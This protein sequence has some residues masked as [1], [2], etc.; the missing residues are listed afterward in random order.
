MAEKNENNNSPG[1]LSG[2]NSSKKISLLRAIILGLL[3]YLICGFIFWV[4]AGVL[5]IAESPQSLDV[6]IFVLYS[7]LVGLVIGCTITYGL[8][9]NKY[10]NKKLLFIF[11]LLSSFFAYLKY[12]PSFSEARWILFF[13]RF[14]VSTL[15]DN[16][17]YFLCFCLVFSGIIEFISYEKTRYSNRFF[18]LLLSCSFFAY[19]ASNIYGKLNYY[20]CN[21]RPLY[22]NEIWGWEVIGSN[23]LHLHLLYAFCL[24]LIIREFVLYKAKQKKCTNKKTIFIWILLCSF[25]IYS[26]FLVITY[27]IAPIE[28]VLSGFW[29]FLLHNNLEVSPVSRL[30]GTNFYHTGRILDGT[31]SHGGV[32]I[33]ILAIPL[34]FTIWFFKLILHGNI[35]INNETI[36]T[37]I[38]IY[39]CIVQYLI[40]VFCAWSYIIYTCPSLSPGS[41]KTLSQKIKEF[42]TS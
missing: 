25:L 23:L 20:Y 41:Y 8:Q 32:D 27:I 18:I 14:S 13:Q 9:E 31:E 30:Y 11:I 6:V 21:H 35:E 5:H 22:Y 19:L 33:S 16:S 3:A 24:S 36:R 10:S 29:S 37:I 1:N 15:L 40:T 28:I 42:L 34:V 17:L 12:T 39:L 26:G 7:C 2:H 38:N 4:M